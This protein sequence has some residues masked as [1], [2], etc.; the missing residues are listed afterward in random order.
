MQRAGHGR[1]RALDQLVDGQEHP[2]RPPSASP[3]GEGRLDIRTPR[4]CPSGHAC[5]GPRRRITLER[6]RCD[7]TSGLRVAR[8]LRRRHRLRRH[9]DAVRHAAPT[10]WPPSPPRSL[11]RPSPSTRFVYSSGTSNILAR[12][13]QHGPGHRGRR[14]RPCAECLT[15][16]LFEPLG[17]TTADPRF[18]PAGTFT[19]SSYVYATTHDFARFGL[20]YLARRHLGRAHHRRP[21]VGRPRPHADRAA[22]R[23][24]YCGYGAH[25]WTHPDDLGTFGCHGYEGQRITLVPALDLVVVRLG[26]TTS[27]TTTSRKAPVDALRRRAHRLL[28]LPDVLFVASVVRAG[29][30]HDPR[31]TQYE[32]RRDPA[33]APRSVDLAVPARPSRARGA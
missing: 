23:S 25:W 18:D 7:M 5:R 32:F 12:A 26:K 10:T 17:M 2:A 4:P 11:P 1:S 16:E 31:R 24:S 6:P 21:R 14:R 19:A 28:R 9:R 27:P 22:T 13:L 33:R 3:C 20:L 8:G 29:Q 15:A 30:P